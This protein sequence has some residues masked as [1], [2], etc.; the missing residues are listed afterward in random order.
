MTQLSPG[1]GAVPPPGMLSRQALTRPSSPC[2]ALPH[3]FSG[4]VLLTLQ[5]TSRRARLAQLEAEM[6]AACEAAALRTN[7]PTNATSAREHW[8]RATWR[9]YLAAAMRLE[10]EYGPRMR[11]LHR[12]IGQLER[13]TAL[14]T[15]V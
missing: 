14:L 10:A 3:P 8:G 5:I 2:P 7:S 1:G 6:I 9:R 15:A 11:R 12:E 13:L 4:Q